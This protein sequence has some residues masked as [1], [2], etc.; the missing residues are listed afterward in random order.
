MK[1]LIL[2]LL[3]INIGTAFYFHNSGTKNNITVQKSLL[4]PEK[5]VLLPPKT[6]CLKWHHLVEPVARLAR[7]AISKWEEGK[8]R[9]TEIS[10]GEVT[11]YWVHIPPL[12]NAHE[13]AQ[14]IAQLENLE[15]SYLY[16]QENKDHPWHNAISLAILTDSFE[17]AELAKYLKSKGIERVVNDK[18]TLA[19]FGFVIRHPTELM[20]HNIQQLAHQLSGTQL[21]TTECSRL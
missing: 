6:T 18:Q 16:I 20:T 11:I 7:V 21:K 4:H 9:V 10:Q 5:I 3:L 17:A 13:T 19:Q 14:Q 1:K 2:L 8:E 15:I 12:S